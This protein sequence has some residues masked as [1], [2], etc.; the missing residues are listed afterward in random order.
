[1]GKTQLIINF[2]Y[3]YVK[4]FCKDKNFFLVMYKYLICKIM[5]FKYK[6]IL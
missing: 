5:K 4:N 3:L 1:M 6:F 2:T